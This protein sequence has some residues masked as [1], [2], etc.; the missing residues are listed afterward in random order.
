MANEV[1]LQPQIEFQA[2]IINISNIVDIQEYVNNVVDKY[3]NVLVTDETKDDAK[4]ARKQLKLVKEQLKSARDEITKKL[5]ENYTPLE[6]QLKEMETQAQNAWRKVQDQ[7]AEL[8]KIQA[9]KKANERRQKIEAYIN[10]KNADI[11]FDT[12]R[13]TWG[14][15]WLTTETY[16][17][18]FAE[19]DEQ[20]QTIKKADEALENERVLIGELATAWKLDPDVYVSLVGFG[21]IETIKNRMKQAVETRQK[22]EAFEQAERERL[23]AEKTAPKTPLVEVEREVVQS[24]DEQVKPSPVQQEVPKTLRKVKTLIVNVN[25]DEYKALIAFMKQNG[26]Q[27]KFGNY[28]G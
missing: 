26:I 16:T 10:E 20:L 17:N 4:E 8:D 21:D 28:E 13:I 3:V 6:N 12:S 25:V 1:S 5:T 9:E 14:S 27:H 7:I 23:L 2:P 22:R 18:I 24:V 15:K 11:Q 19:V